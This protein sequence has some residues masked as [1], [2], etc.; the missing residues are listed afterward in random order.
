M[1]NIANNAC[2]ALASW[3]VRNTMNSI[4][5][6]EEKAYQVRRLSIL[7]TTAAGSGHMT[8]A[9]SC[10]DIMA[11]L[12]FH[13]MHFDP[14]QP[15][16][17]HNDRFILSKGHAAPALYA[18]WQQLGA[19]T[20][21]QLLQMRSI[22]SDLE[23]H[24]T[25][26]FSRAEVATGSLGMGLSMGAGMALYAKRFVYNYR[27]YVLLGDSELAEG[28]NWEAFEFIHYNKINNL[29]A[30]IDVNSLGQRGTTM[31][32]HSIEPLKK[33]IEAFGWKVFEV[34]GHSI[35]ALVDLFD[36]I[37]TVEGPIA[38]L[39]KTIKGYGTSIEG[40][41]GWH[42]KAFKKEQEEQELYLLNKRFQNRL[43]A[44][45]EKFKPQLP[46][47]GTWHI[48][49]QPH[50]IASSSLRAQLSTVISPRKA[51]GL[52]LQEYV[53]QDQCCLVF[54]GEVSNSTFTE[55]V[56]KNEPQQFVE[57]FIAEQ[58][59]VGVAI[60]ANK[61]NAR[62]IVATFAAFFTR[63]HD[64]L[65]MSALSK[66]TLLLAGS[67][68]GV[69]I[70]EDGASQMGLEDI[71]LFRAIP[72]TIILYPADGNA[73]ASCMQEALKYRE[74][75]AYLRLTRADVPTLYSGNEEFKLG[76]SHLLRSAPDDKVL[77]IAAGITVHEALKAHKSLQ[78]RGIN[79]AVLDAYSIAPLD[80]ETIKKE[81][82]RVG[83]KLV[84]VE[85]HY[86]AGGLGEA[87]F[88]V[89]IGMPLQAKHLCV[90][91]IPHSGSP[92]AA[93][94]Y[95]GID[96]KAIENAVLDLMV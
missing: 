63:A 35:T 89:C 77:I 1:L 54:D 48:S 81:L 46:E 27:T 80:Q 39:A 50:F 52:T 83:K 66:T 16:Y 93:M 24:A 59:M 57:C 43:K 87:V 86:Q 85:D 3:N 47:P 10:A 70:G 74:G 15:D 6:L 40:K 22:N 84:V 51:F 2:L 72:G 79:A 60:G 29:I 94:A 61:R 19:L 49:E 65:R 8:S 37:R 69:S 21:Q 17:E 91:T 58:N 96:D 12:F 4:A 31:F 33:R 73:T 78:M 5:F 14:A 34:D 64:Q 32:G 28:S 41:Q 68:V 20:E 11:V 38:I 23:G 92:L 88:A 76:G 13:V 45:G 44:G 95:V 75:N 25:F 55:F 71:A 18:I 53:K 90:K 56:E 67:H 30:I 36:M 9:L 26:R 62:C 82:E 42:G 7:A